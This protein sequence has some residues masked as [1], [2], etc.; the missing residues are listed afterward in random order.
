MTIEDLLIIREK[1]I[2]EDTSR[3]VDRAEIRY[4]PIHGKELPSKYYIT[5]LHFVLGR[6]ENGDVYVVHEHCNSSDGRTFYHRLCRLPE[7]EKRWP[8]YR[9]IDKDDIK[10]YTSLI[11]A[12]GKTG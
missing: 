1:E 12:T 9:Q 11:P 4:N 6:S 5:E 3:I 7:D 10:N 2:H 8:V